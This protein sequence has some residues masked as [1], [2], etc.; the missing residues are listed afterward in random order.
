MKKL[1]KP[2]SII[3]TGE[4]P[5]ILLIVVL[6]I[7]NHAILVKKNFLDCKNFLYKIRKE[8]K[9]PYYFFHKISVQNSPLS[10]KN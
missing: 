2:I 3:R 4:Q 1:V 8:R 6:I 7:Y 5:N 10:H 9:F